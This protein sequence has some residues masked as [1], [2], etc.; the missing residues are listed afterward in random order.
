MTV[1]VTFIIENLPMI[2]TAAVQLVV[3]LVDGLI[4][5]LPTLV[6]RAL[7]LVTAIWDTLK[8]V[9]LDWLQLGIDLIKGIGD[10]LVSGVKQIGS[11]IGNVAGS[12]GGKFKSFLGI[13]SPSRVMKAE[14]GFNMGAGVAEG[15]KDTKGMMNNEIKS[16]TD[17]MTVTMSANTPEVI[18]L[19]MEPYQLPVSEEPKKP[20][21]PQDPS[22][23]G[24]E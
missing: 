15:L 8:G 5:A 17:D 11:T 18:I 12:I 10:G 21:K 19:T 23:G 6:E 13:H 9:D 22:G 14:V 3:V 24:D 7:N 20:T 4:S 1:L 2:L 16:L